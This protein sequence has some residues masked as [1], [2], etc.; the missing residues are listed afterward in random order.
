MSDIDPHYAHVAAVHA[1]NN[2]LVGKPTQ[3][4]NVNLG[5]PSN[6]P[7]DVGPANAWAGQ[8][9]RLYYKTR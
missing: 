9:K 8:E 6:K 3:G 1:R 4:P 2:G 5:V 7:R